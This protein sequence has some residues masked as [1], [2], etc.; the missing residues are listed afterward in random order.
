MIEFNLNKHLPKIV[1]ETKGEQ[2]YLCRVRK[3]LLNITPEET[4]RQAFLTYLIEEQKVPEQQLLLEVPLPN[5]QNKI[6]ILVLDDTNAPLIIYE[7]YKDTEKT[8]NSAIP[9]AI[10]YYETIQSIDYV[11]VVKGNQIDLVSFVHN[12]EEVFVVKYTK[13]PNYTTL[14]QGN[15][16]NFIQ[17]QP[18]RDLLHPIN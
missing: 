17:T 13:H 15:E 7:W 14:C 5:Q 11:G 6:D 18:V 9:T 8:A 16:N 2:K 3:I 4:R 10:K 12:R 1:W